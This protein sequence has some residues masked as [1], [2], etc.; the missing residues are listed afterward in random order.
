MSQ[1]EIRLTTLN[2]K[3]RVS[4]YVSLEFEAHKIKFHVRYRGWCSALHADLS[5]EVLE[6]DGGVV[7][8]GS[9][10]SLLVD[11]DEHSLVV[12]V[13]AVIVGDLVDQLLHVLELIHVGVGHHDGD[14][15][16]EGGSILE[17]DG[18]DEGVV[19]PLDGLVVDVLPDGV[20]GSG[21]LEELSLLCDEVSLGVSTLGLLDNNLLDGG[22]LLFRNRL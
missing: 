1:Y 4:E 17:N 7:V 11:L 20:A 22:H 18:H 19:L 3:C 10:A 16:G 9:T 2:K 14:E 21:P 12:V 13:D 15:S 8:G 6:L 5:C